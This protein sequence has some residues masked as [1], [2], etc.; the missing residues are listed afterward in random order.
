M[1]EKTFREYKPLY[2][3]MM[4]VSIIFL[5]MM[6][7]YLI[8]LEGYGV[9]ISALETLIAVASVILLFSILLFF[10]DAPMYKVV[11]KIYKKR[12]IYPPQINPPKQEI[13]EEVKNNG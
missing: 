11:G 3:I 5:V 4:L 6:I 13:L 8:I 1:T 2:V 12:I 7:P 9:N 10:L